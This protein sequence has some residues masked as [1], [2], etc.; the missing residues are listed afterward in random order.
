MSDEQKLIYKD[1]QGPSWSPERKNKRVIFDKKNFLNKEKVSESD[2]QATQES[3]KAIALIRAYRIR[4]HLIA[5]LDPLG[6]MERK[7]LEDLN[8]EDH[9]FTKDDYN[10]KIYVGAYMQGGYSTINEILTFFRKIY[11]STVGVEYMHISDPVEKK[12]F[13]SRMEKTE[14]QL[15]FTNNGKKAILNKLIQAEG[16]EKFL[17]VKFV[18]TKRFGLDGGEALIP[19][20][21]QIIKRG[22]HLGFKEVKIGQPHRGRLNILANVLQKSYKRMFNEFAGEY[23]KH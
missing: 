22:G 10:K 1:L 23:A 8:P 15:R 12:W 16:F 19:A 7:Y 2:L 21:E 3:V 18:G 9:G 14:N 20:L 11:C 5:N 17:A 6:M 4:G 13:R